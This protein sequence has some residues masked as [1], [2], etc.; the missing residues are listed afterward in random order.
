MTFWLIL[1]LAVPAFL[2]T[3]YPLLRPRPQANLLPTAGDEELED[4]HARRDAAYEALKDL[5]FEF[6]SGG[7]SE[8]DYRDLEQKY[9]DR[10]ISVLQRLDSMTAPSG[11]EE[12]IESQVL[13]LRKGKDAATEGTECSECGTASRPE[14]RFC[15]RC[16]ASLYPEP[17]VCPGCQTE[18]QKGDRFCAQCGARLTDA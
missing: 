1:L 12:E 7:R 4:L 17:L 3:L 2:F 16:G 11:I 10:A 6:Q 18:F 8:K 14:D 15:T 13:K 9:K 5:E